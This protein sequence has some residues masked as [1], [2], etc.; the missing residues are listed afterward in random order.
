VAATGTV[1]EAIGTYGNNGFG[2]YCTI[3]VNGSLICNGFLSA[4][5]PVNNGQQQVALYGM[6]SPENWFEDFGSGQLSN[7]IAIINLEAVFAQTVNTNTSY[8]VFLT[9]NGD[10]RGLFIAQKTP[11]SFEVREQGGGAS[12]IAFDYR[13]VARRK[14][15]ETV[16]L[17]DQTAQFQKS[18]ALLQKKRTTPLRIPNPRRPS[19]STSAALNINAVA[20][21][22]H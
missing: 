19:S 5:A 1:L 10:S 13:I 6:Q 8:H 21:Q 4:V 18:R 11:T 12:N 9:P 2:G 20:N 14:G 3:D 7:G 16:R 22:A 15:F 17:A